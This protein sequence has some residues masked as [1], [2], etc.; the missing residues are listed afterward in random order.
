M[1]DAPLPSLRKTPPPAAKPA[2]PAAPGS[3][4]AGRVVSG[5]LPLPPAQLMRPAELDADEAAVFAALKIDP[6]EGIPENF[7]AALA[8]I[9]QDMADPPLP[10]SPGAK[11]PAI[12]IK[13]LQ[14]LSPAELAQM[15]QNAQA[16]VTSCRASEAAEASS[17]SPMVK[18]NVKMAEAAIARAARA[19][20]EAAQPPRTP[21]FRR[22]SEI[23][24]DAPP[25]EEP[26]PAA[27]PAEAPVAVPAAPADSGLDEVPKFCPH[28]KADL[29]QPP[30]PPPTEDEIDTYVL[31]LVLGAE[32]PYVKTY[33]LGTA[34]TPIQL[35]FRRLSLGE[36]DACAREALVDL[37]DNPYPSDAI[38]FQTI[39]RYQTCLQ[40]YRI[41]IG[42]KPQPMPVALDEWD[43]DP[44]S[45][46]SPL[47]QVMGWFTTVGPFRDPAVLRMASLYAGRF[48]ELVG[49][50]EAIVS[51]PNFTEPGAAPA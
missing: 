37:K 51:Q 21:S 33:N 47:R 11:P 18:A 4:A 25:P 8:E 44:D 5:R 19:G 20:D 29:A 40:L 42:A 45:K 31:S 38:L 41:Q 23:V 6:R 34:K 30:V 10:V 14:D 27:P 35:T 28:C 1:A 36:L 26:P 32:H 15:Q 7:A 2:K 49:A 9:A 17:L 3:R 16:L 43:L 50:M 13:Q 22:F 46:D 24:G 48:N 39:T 12:T